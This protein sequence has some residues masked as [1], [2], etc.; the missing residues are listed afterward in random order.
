MEKTIRTLLIIALSLVGASLLFLLILIPLQS[1]L[2]RVLNLP[3]S[4]LGT[5]PIFPVVPFLSCI[6]QGACIVLLFLFCGK[7]GEGS[8]WAEILVAAVFV[9]VLPLAS[10]LATSAYV[11]SLARFYRTP[12]VLAAYASISRFFSYCTYPAT[13]GQVLAVVVCG[14]SAVY[15]RMAQKQNTRQTPYYG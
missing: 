14:M 9:V 8:V 11:N 3:A 6:A 15:K 5:L 7:R 13:W 1:F 2:G 4:A 10:N 12:E